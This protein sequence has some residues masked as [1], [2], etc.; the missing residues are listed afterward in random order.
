MNLADNK[1]DDR[2][3][4]E[5]NDGMTQADIGMTTHINTHAA[6]AKSVVVWVMSSEASC[7][8]WLHHIDTVLYCE[9]VLVWQLLWRPPTH[10][11]FLSFL[12]SDTKKMKNQA[13]PDTGGDVS[14]RT[15]FCEMYV[16]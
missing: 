9:T 4:R 11:T 13:K 15:L 5:L 2:W 3:A 14:V 1:T 8:Y 6:V 7:T 12:C 10:Q 16:R